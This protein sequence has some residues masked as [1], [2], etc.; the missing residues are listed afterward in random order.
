ME[1]SRQEH[2]R[3]LTFPPPG[4]LSGPGIKLASTAWQAYTSQCY[5]P[6]K[7]KKQY[8]VRMHKHNLDVIY[9]VL[10]KVMLKL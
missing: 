6:K 4:N 10:L 5:I 8:A 7:G 2:W 3:E 1:F 9:V